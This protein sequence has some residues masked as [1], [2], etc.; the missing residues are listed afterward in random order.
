MANLVSPS[1]R[2]AATL[3]IGLL[4]GGIALFAACR[5]W[6]PYAERF[7]GRRSLAVPVLAVLWVLPTALSVLAWEEGRFIRNGLV[8]ECL[9]GLQWPL[10]TLIAACLAFTLWARGYVLSKLV[11]T[12]A[13]SFLPLF[14]YLGGREHVMLWN[15][16]RLV[17]PLLLLCAAVIPPVCAGLHAW[18]GRADR[19]RGGIAVAMGLIVTA[20]GLA[21]VARWPAPYLVR[22]ERGAGRWVARVERMFGDSFTLFDYFHYSF[23]FAVTGER[24][25]VGI[26]D[27]VLSR[28]RVFPLEEFRPALPR[29]MAWLGTKAREERVLIVA[30]FTPP[31]LEAGVLLKEVAVESVTLDRIRNK[32]ALPAERYPFRIDVTLCEVVP[33]ET[34]SEPL[35]TRVVLDGGYLGLRSPWGRKDIPIK[36]GDGRKL[37]ACWTREGSGVIGPVPHPEGAV[38]VEVV[39]TA[40]R[41]DGEEAQTLIIRPPW[42][43][44]PLNLE[45]PN[46]VA[47]VS[48]ILKRPVFAARTD[49]RTG[50]YRIYSEKQYDPGKIGIRGFASDLGARVH[51]IA[52]REME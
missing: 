32:R 35:R 2:L 26:T 14:L 33:V 48:G 38:E 51:S 43:G 27:R 21:N 9:S 6:M 13:F 28:R 3:G 4:L 40:G 16:R 46:E 44:E 8:N 52:M 31:G 41:R 45:I 49:E 30:A 18:L 7:F 15:Q 50:V 22:F 47:T 37:S 19:R 11:L 39:A 1:F 12:L 24:R 23:P 34:V 17:L 10:A 25:A 20:I 36:L 5:L 29:L 42:E